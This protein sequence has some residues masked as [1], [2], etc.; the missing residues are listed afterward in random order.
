MKEDVKISKIPPFGL[1]L[2]PRLRIAIEVSA[3]SNNRSM[4]SEILLQLE[5]IY[6]KEM[7]NDQR[8]V[9]KSLEKTIS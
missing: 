5:R 9:D 7:G 8:F 4:N 3:K 2:P 6:K 1:R